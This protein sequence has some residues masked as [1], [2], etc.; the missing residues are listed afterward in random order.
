MIPKIDQILEEQNALSLIG[1]ESFY[2]FKQNLLQC[3]EVYY[4]L[5][6]IDDPLISAKGS[7]QPQ[8]VLP[9]YTESLIAYF[10]L[11]EEQG[12]RN[13][14]IT[15]LEYSGVHTIKVRYK[16]TDSVIKKLVKLGLRDPKVLEDPLKIFLNGGALHDLIGIL[17]ICAYPYEK[18]WVARTLYNFFEYDHRTDDHLLYGFY[19]VEKKSGYRALHCDHTLFNPRFDASVVGKCGDTTPVDPYALFSLLEPDDSATEVLRKLK[20]YFNIEIQLHTTFENLWS[21]MEHTNSYNIQAKGL[22][23]S[24]KITV[25]WKLLSDMMKNLETQ[26]EQLQVDT[27][28]ARF[29]VLHHTS[30]IPVKE[31]LDELGSDTY[32]IHA[33]VTKTIETLETLLKSHEISRQEYVARLQEKAAYLEDFAQE[34]QNLTVRMVFQMQ[35]AFIYYG[36]ANQRDYFNAEDI[37]QF[38]QKALASYE[39]IS[40]F[41]SSHPEIYLGNLLNII[42]I[43]RYLYLGHK[44]GLGLMN[45]PETIVTD[46][47]IPSLSPAQNLHFF[48]TAISLLNGLSEEEIGYLNK[49]RTNTLKIIHHY[50]LLAREWELFNGQHDSTSAAK[51]SE[52]VEEFRSRYITNELHRHFNILLESDKIKNIGFVVKF[53]TTLVWHGFYLPMDALKQIIRYSAYDK[54]KPSD[55]FYYELAAYRFLYLRRCNTLEDCNKPFSQRLGDPVKVEHFGNYHRKNMIQLL[56]RIKR[57][58][59]AYKFHKARLYFEQ[60]T[61]TKFKM[62]HF[63]GMVLKESQSEGKA[64]DNRHIG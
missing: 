22:G 11:L 49:D 39:A 17:F 3:M 46:E 10:Q 16:Y 4:R 33:E 58:E 40:T 13:K 37:R 42:T 50:D 53:Y 28:Q 38:V 64:L 51:I 41:L 2:I 57:S 45:P 15:A 54:I 47:D 31:L 55:L 62:D 24:S 26:F 63:S 29:E 14:E 18:E 23:R 9:R 44:Y 8:G 61:Q 34:Q 48:K 30:Y 27:E 25:Q 56:F 7:R 5:V 43:F 6:G 19:T 32:P 1:E 52:A 59:S 12:S 60:L 36:L 20:D 21:S 35:S